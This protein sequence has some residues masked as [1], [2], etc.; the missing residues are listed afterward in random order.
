M[1]CFKQL[2]IIAIILRVIICVE[3]ALTDVLREFFLATMITWGFKVS[4]S[5]NHLLQDS[6]FSPEKNP[7]KNHTSLD[8]QKDKQKKEKEKCWQWWNQRKSN[9][10]CLA[11]SLQPELL[12]NKGNFWGITLDPSH[13]WPKNLEA[14]AQTLVKR[15]SFTFESDSI[16]KHIIKSRKAWL[17][18][19]K[20]KALECLLFKSRFRLIQWNICTVTRRWLPGFSNCTGTEHFRKKEI[21]LV[22]NGLPNRDKVKRCFTSVCSVSSFYLDPLYI[23]K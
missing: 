1:G 22:L 18:Q 16:Q 21:L 15:K 20:I 4:A 6:N 10:V 3:V 17:H 12:C 11:E 7:P 2:L 13:F 23:S 5:A 9:Q 8:G 19:N 14:S